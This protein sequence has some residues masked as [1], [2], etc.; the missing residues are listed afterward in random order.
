MKA[1]VIGGSGAT[2][3]YLVEELLAS[4]QYREVVLFL[5]R[6]SFKEHP[7]LK[8]VV[9]DFNKINE[10]EM[11]ADVAFSCLGTTLKAAGS[12]E[13]QWKIDYDYQFNFAQRAKENGV[14]NFVLVSAIN[15]NSKSKLF[16]AKLK[17]AIEEAVVDLDFKHTYIFQPSILIRPE[18]KR[19]GEK[20]SAHISVFLGRIGLLN[21]YG[22]THVKMLAKA[23]VFCVNQSSAKLSYIGVKGIKKLNKES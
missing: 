16:Y 10:L 8:Q 23:M 6:V 21:K 15:A 4:N 20:I 1:V 22:A 3:R 14:S 5:R 7:K 13:A 12:K 9:I 2:G 11:N 19:F 17:G 18:S